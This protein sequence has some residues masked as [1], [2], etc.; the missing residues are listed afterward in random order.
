MMIAY[1]SIGSGSILILH[2]LLNSGCSTGLS[3]TAG[4]RGDGGG[5]GGGRGRRWWGRWW[6]GAG[7][8]G[9]LLA[10]LLA[11]GVGGVG[12]HVRRVRVRPDHVP[13]GR[14]AHLPLRHD[15]VYLREYVLECWFHIRGVES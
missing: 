4:A 9:V 13:L 10:A 12:A 15:P 6:W 8:V 7:G 11:H 5:G 14:I 2:L 1:L 3:E